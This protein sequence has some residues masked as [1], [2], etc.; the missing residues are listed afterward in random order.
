MPKPVV[1]TNSMF[2]STFFVG[3][4]D[5]QHKR[6]QVIEFTKIKKFYFTIT[7]LGLNVT[8]LHDDLPD[9]FVATWQSDLCR[10]SKVDI[11]KYKKEFG[12]RLGVNDIR[13][14][15]FVEVIQQ[16]PEWENVFVL[17]GFDVLVAMNP[18]PSLQPG[19]LYVGSE[20]TC[21]KRNYWL[22]VRFEDMGGDYLKWYSAQLD[23]QTM[24]LN[25][26]I[27]GGSRDIILKLFKRLQ[28]VFLD[29][30]LKA[31]NDKRE[32][33]VNMAALNY[34]VYKEMSQSLVT[35]EPV[36]SKYWKQQNRRKDVWFIHK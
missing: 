26:G 17:D 22:K 11:K 2:L 36:H 1:A 24:T 3:V 8:M 7:S 35:G 33:N 21:L 29:E 20:P 14:F 9:E 16:H 4:K 10:F 18:F 30:S 5:W 31:R 13:Y 15:A 25:C 19:K 12:F 28:E 32:V 27:T 23:T 34:V 6:T